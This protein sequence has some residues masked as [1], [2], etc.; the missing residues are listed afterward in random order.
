MNMY[1]IKTI[2]NLFIENLALLVYH[3][4]SCLTFG[5]VAGVSA[6]TA[7]EWKL[8]RKVCAAKNSMQSAAPWKMKMWP[9]VL[10]TILASSLAVWMSGCFALPTMHTDSSMGTCSKIITRKVY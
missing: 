5:V 7:R 6:T 1:A 9:H 8:L 2:F 4:S 3:L 10:W